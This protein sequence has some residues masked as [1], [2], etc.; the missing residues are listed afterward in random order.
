MWLENVEFALC[1]LP[2]AGCHMDLVW[3]TACV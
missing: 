2:S 3:L 1:L